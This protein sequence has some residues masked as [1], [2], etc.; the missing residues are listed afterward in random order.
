MSRIQPSSVPLEGMTDEQ[1]T[2]LLENA[3]DWLRAKA[4]DLPKADQ[5]D[6]GWR[7]EVEE[8][9][10]LRRL[11]SGLQRGEVLP[12]DRMARKLAARTV[13]ETNTLDSLREE[14]RRELAEHMAWASL[15][16][17]FDGA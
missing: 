12:G 6:D 8:V 11:V 7:V 17:R 2:L 9:A 1:L 10:A 3:I 15:L 16:A 4:A 14:Y 13:S 5:G